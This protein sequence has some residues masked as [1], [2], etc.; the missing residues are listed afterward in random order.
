MRRRSS[1]RVTTGLPFVA[2]DRLPSP[3]AL[4]QS[5]WT[6]SPDQCAIRGRDWSGTSARRLPG[7]AGGCCVATKGV[8][9]FAWYFPSFVDV[10]PGCNLRP[11]APG[12]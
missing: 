2:A 9:G 3:T 12:K 11:A 6:N 1:A 4:A 10:G 5:R 8:D 7:D